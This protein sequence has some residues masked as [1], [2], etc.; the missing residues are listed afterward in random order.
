M[1]QI[2]MMKYICTLLAISLSIT[3]LAQTK[4][5]SFLKGNKLLEKKDFKGAKEAFSAALEQDSTLDDAYYNR[6]VAE[7]NLKE[8]DTALLDFKIYNL[9]NPQDEDTMNFISF[10]YYFNDDYAGLKASVQQFMNIASTEYNSNYFLGY[11]CYYLDEYKP[12]IEYLTNQLTLEP[13]NQDALFYRAKSYMKLDQAEEAE[14][15]LTKLIILKD[16]YSL[17]HYY[18]AI[19]RKNRKNY[20]EALEDIHK[21]V[22]QNPEDTNFLSLRGEI[23]ETLGDSL[24]AK[25]DYDKAIELKGSNLYDVL[26]KRALVNYLQLGDKDAAMTDLNELIKSSP[27]PNSAAFFIRGLLYTENDQLEEANAD[28]ESL[29]KLDSTFTDAYYYWAD[30]KLKMEQYDEALRLITIYLKDAET[31]SES[32]LAYAYQLIGK[33]RLQ[34]KDFAAALQ[35]FE[36]SLAHDD[37]LGE[38]HF[39]FAKTLLALKRKEEACKSLYK[40]LDLG[41]EDAELELEESCGYSIPL[42]EDEE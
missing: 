9:L 29:N 33:M 32:N 12:A 15:D 3:V 25:T 37:E 35:A 38:T 40:A 22:Q 42:E 24:A 39:W 8:M 1:N 20:L 6:A 26:Y 17:A 14:Q 5:S 36:Q 10:I 16:D 4:N 27:E 13:T 30:V 31:L 19:I 41:Y 21:S 34:Q 11:A 18:R 2:R 28:F 7:F 23:Q